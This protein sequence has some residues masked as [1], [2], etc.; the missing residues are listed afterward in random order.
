[1]NYW[2]DRAADPDDEF[3][4]WRHFV[5]QCGQERIDAILNRTGG[6]A[7]IMRAPGHDFD[8]PLTQDLLA[9][10]EALATMLL[11]EVVFRRNA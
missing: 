9:S 7:R 6:T 11:A 4:G 2:W 10:D 3:G 8:V 5:V 1:M